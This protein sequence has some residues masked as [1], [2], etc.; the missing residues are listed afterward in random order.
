MEPLNAFF[1]DCT[2]SSW[3]K[4]EGEAEGARVFDIR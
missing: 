1:K 3:I 4:V 2:G